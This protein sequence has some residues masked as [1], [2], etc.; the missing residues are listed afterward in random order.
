MSRTSATALLSLILSI[1]LPG[2]IVLIASCAQ[3]A[4]R[5]ERT[6]DLLI[7][8]DEAEVE[9]PAGARRPALLGDAPV[10][11]DDERLEALV[12]VGTELRFRDVP[13]HPRATLRYAI[14][15][16]KIEPAV[17]ADPIHVSL[18]FQRADGTRE[19][20]DE[21]ELGAR[22]EGTLDLAKLAGER[23]TLVVVTKAK[24]A[25]PA[26]AAWSLLRVD[27]DGRAE[28]ASDRTFE[29]ER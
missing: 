12:D 22:R 5:R 4:P 27:S 7:A 26:R 29:I 11:T 24:S 19:T 17:W 28:R 16:S 10:S 15:P 23:G 1:V 14:G 25:A 3:T 13:I 20:L 2:L 8:L 18:A 9:L 21:F 6:I